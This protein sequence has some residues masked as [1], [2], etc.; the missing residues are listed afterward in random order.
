MNLAQAVLLVAY[1]LRLGS[2]QPAPAPVAPLAPASA[3]EEAMA[4]LREALLGIGYLQAQNPEAVLGELRHMLV[5]ARPS[6]REVTLLRG[7]ARQVR[8][9]ASLVARRSEP[10]G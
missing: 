7:L 2:P 1:E 3:V 6:P 9:A 8:W 4:E 10:S 5:R